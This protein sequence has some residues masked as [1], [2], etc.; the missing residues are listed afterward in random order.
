MLDPAGELDARFAWHAIGRARRGEIRPRAREGSVP[1]RA[2][3]RG[4]SPS[5][6]RSDLLDLEER[7]RPR[8][9]ARQP[10]RDPHAHAGLAPA[11]L[12]DAPH[13]V[14]DQLLGDLVAPH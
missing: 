13:A 6:A 12:D 8:T 7:G 1:L 2:H 10:G 11:E 3:G 14:A 9:P 5:R 4:L